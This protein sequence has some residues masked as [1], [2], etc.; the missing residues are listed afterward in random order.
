[1]EKKVS[2]SIPM[3]DGNETRKHLSSHRRT[4]NDGD[5]TFSPITSAESLST[6]PKM[7]N[8]HP[9]T[10]TPSTMA[11]TVIFG[12]PPAVFCTGITLDHFTQEGSWY[13]DKEM[14]KEDYRHLVD[15]AC[16]DMGTLI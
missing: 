10:L 16:H 12:Q 15:K 14:I 9:V 7:R 11:P 5:S 4:L 6:R 8:T 1:M 3:L 13:R 2:I